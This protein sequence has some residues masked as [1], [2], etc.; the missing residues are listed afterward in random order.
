[1]SVFELRSSDPSLGRRLATYLRLLNQPDAAEALKIEMTIDKPALSQVRVFP[2]T[3]DLPAI[4]AARWADLCIIGIQ[5]VQSSGQGTAFLNGIS[6]SSGIDSYF[7]ANAYSLQ[8]A[9]SAT[10]AMGFVV[11]FS[12][13]QIIVT[14][15]S[16]GGSAAIAM[17]AGLRR[18]GSPGARRAITFGSPRPG[19]AALGVYVQD[20]DIVRWMTAGDPVPGIAPRL[21]ESSAAHA[22]LT[23]DRSLAW[24]AQQQTHGGLRVD[25]AGSVELAG[26]ADVSSVSTQTD[27]AAWLWSIQQDAVSAHSIQTYINYL[28]GAANQAFSFQPGSGLHRSL[29]PAPRI[30]QRDIN[31]ARGE[32]N[33]DYAAATGNMAKR[34][35]KMPPVE[36]MKH[37]AIGGIWVVTWQGRVFAIGP[38]RARAR[39]MA[40]SGNTWL[41]RMQRFGLVSLESLKLSVGDYLSRASSDG[42]GFDPVMRT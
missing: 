23:N 31:E 13:P 9:T 5:G 30:T 40:R 12:A 1:M 7:G 11:G 29:D 41:R 37:E 39:D 27:I 8:T 15:H 28:A 2:A 32:V 22:L 19:P 3:A 33:R 38:Q 6:Q 18:A 34:I 24:N 4:F 26:T 14:G 10:A 35:F 17:L 21:S 36:M 16:Q 25:A 20:M 42:N